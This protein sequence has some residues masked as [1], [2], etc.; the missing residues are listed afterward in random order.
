VDA[1]AFRDGVPSLT[2]PVARTPAPDAL[3]YT[4]CFGI[5]QVKRLRNKDMS[6]ADEYARTLS[7]LTGDGFQDEV[8]TRLHSAILSFQTIPR[9]P[10]GDAGLDGLSHD[11]EHA[12]CC[13][14]PE[15]DAFKKPKDR[16][17]AI[18]DKFKGDLRRLF[19][20]DFENRKP[21][22]IENKEIP[23]ILREGGK[24]KHIKLIV[25]WFE[26]HRVV[27]PISTAVA[28]YKQLSACKYV[29]PGASVIIMGPKELANA[30]PVDASTILGSRQRIFFKEVQSASELVQI[31]NPTDFDAK[32]TVL[33]E[34][35]PS[36]ICTIE[37][38]KEQFLADWRMALAFERKLDETMPALHQA[39]DSNRRRIL[40][41]VAQLM[42]GSDRPWMELER[43]GEVASSVLAHDFK[44]YG[45][46]L[47]GAI[48][49]GEVARLIGEC[50]IT[51]E[52]QGNTHA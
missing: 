29:D 32:M 21:I 2:V 4:L 16:E 12:Y 28:Q 9:K 38:L 45:E 51:W 25:N 41:R 6:L 31:E 43:A 46:T 48:S 23:T 52:A 40:Q 30:Y 15:H 35:C 26:S 49:S 27:G 20:L 8:C 11:G 3:W 36:Q 37:G 22:R 1:T 19:E 17:R 7:Q 14:G 50:P 13:Y 10:H 18:V 47:L 44:T 33:C 24:L 5:S 42:L 39:L 34:I